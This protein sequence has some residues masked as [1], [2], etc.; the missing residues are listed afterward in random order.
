MSAIEH[1][2][3]RTPIQVRFKDIDSMGHVNN[4][5]HFTYFELARVKYFE[6]VVNEPVEWSRRGIILAHMSIDYKSPV[7]L[8]DEVSVHCRV[9]RFGNS[10]FDC[11][12]LIICRREGQDVLAASGKSTQVCFDYDLNKPYPVPEVWKTRT[13]TYES[14]K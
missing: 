10:S 3:H 11:E 14:G 8:K 9:S 12:Y 2:R 1:F 7:Y 5:N 13:E 6:D 4:A